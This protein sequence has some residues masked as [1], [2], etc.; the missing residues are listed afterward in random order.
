MQRIYY[1][2]GIIKLEF[3]MINDKKNGECK[4]YYEE[5]QLYVN[6]SYIDENGQLKKICSYIDDKKVE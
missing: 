2:S 1:D 6:C 4:E 5:G 3:F